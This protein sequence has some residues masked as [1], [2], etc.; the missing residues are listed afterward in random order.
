MEEMLKDKESWRSKMESK[1]FHP[2][3]WTGKR[4]PGSRE[5]ERGMKVPEQ[6][7]LMPCSQENPREKARPQTSMSAC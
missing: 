3:P 7:G 6:W 5:K 4:S 1:T 2:S